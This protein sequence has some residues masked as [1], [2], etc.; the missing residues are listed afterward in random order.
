MKCTIVLPDDST[1]PW[2]SHVPRKRNGAGEATVST[3]LRLVH[4]LG[5]V[6]FF[7]PLILLEKPQLTALFSGKATNFSSL[8][9][10]LLFFL[11]GFAQEPYQRRPKCGIDHG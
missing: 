3:S 10:L 6:F 5:E 1:Q 8:C 2:F 7:E 4:F 9:L 11:T